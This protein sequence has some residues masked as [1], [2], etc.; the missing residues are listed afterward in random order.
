MNL[1][2]FLSAVFSVICEVHLTRF[3]DAERDIALFTTPF[4]FHS[5]AI[6]TLH[7]LRETAGTWHADRADVNCSNFDRFPFAC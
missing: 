7:P 5:I 3:N 2:Y 1:K 4:C 6:R